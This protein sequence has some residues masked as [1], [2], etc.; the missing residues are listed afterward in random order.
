MKNT[1]YFGLGFITILLSAIIII[2]SSKSARS[3]N[4]ALLI[5]DKS[6]PLFDYFSYNGND[7][8]YNENALQDS[9]FFF[10]PIL[11]GWHSD[12]SI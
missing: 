5:S 3:E 10:N 8:F 1:Y 4:K 9:S 7:S 11:P 12:P 2:F 6:V